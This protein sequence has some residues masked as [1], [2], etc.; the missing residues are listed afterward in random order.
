[1]AN[2]KAEQERAELHKA[3]WSIAE[4]LRGSVGGWEFKNYVLGMMFYRYLSE[5]ITHKLNKDEWD[6]SNKEFD[7]TRLSDEEATCIREDMFDSLGYF[8][9]PSE[10]FCN[11]RS[12]A[13]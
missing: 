13:A 12:K 10:L 8:L 5:H 2:I 4:D 1:M 11:V 6:A 9:L 3:I 7:Y